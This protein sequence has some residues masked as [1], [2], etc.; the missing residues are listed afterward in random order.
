MKCPVLG[1]I[2]SLFLVLTGFA[3]GTSAQPLALSLGDI[4][5]AMDPVPEARIYV[6]KRIITMDPRR[7]RGEAVAVLGGRILAVGSLDDLIHAAGE[8]PLPVDETF[9]DKVLV[10]GFIDP[11]V[12]PALA[13][14][15]FDAEIISFEDWALPDGLRPG[16][17]GHDEYLK[18]LAEAQ[19]RLGDGKAVMV[20]WGYHEG[21]H[22]PLTRDD[23]DAISNKR[24]IIVWHRSGRMFILNSPAIERYGISEDFLARLPASAQSDSDRPAG[25]FRGQGA[26]AILERISPALAEPQALRK[27]LELLE[28][29]LHAGGLTAIASPDEIS[30]GSL[31][32][33]QRAVLGDDATPFRT[34][35]LPDGRSIAERFRADPRRMLE[36]TRALSER[37]GGRNRVLPG[38]VRLYLDGSLFSARM[39]VTGGYNDGEQGAWEMDPELFASAFESYWDAGYQI[40]VQVN[41]DAA[42]QLVLERLERE[43]RRKPR[44]DHRTTL[45]HFGMASEAQIQQ[46]A[47]LRVAVCGN[48]HVVTAMADLYAHN[49]LGPERADN[50]VPLGAAKRAGLPVSLCSDL[51]MAPAQPLQLIWSAVNRTTLS[52]RVAGSDQRLG[53]EDALAAVTINAA[54]LLRLEDEVGSIEP[55]KLANFTVLESDPFEVPPEQLRSIGV[56][57]TVLEG[58]V[59]AVARPILPARTAA[60][61]PRVAPWLAPV[62]LFESV[63]VAWNRVGE[64]HR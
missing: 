52:G 7:P 28:A 35:Y 15:V 37:A 42:L 51:P 18:R 11:Q 41:G 58:R 47:R 30:P 61:S 43:M 29:Y 36:E 50:L 14:L 3:P 10:P 23:L 1:S 38:Q 34:H 49:G 56:W 16:V 22:G 53:I 63:P 21:F 55:G 46:L 27:G 39:E 2:L 13:A 9:R 64:V 20:T 62:R 19:T 45:V 26:L 6:A 8:Q 44:Y 32:Q 4:R 33:A 17:R 48:P 59:Q 54:Y 12:H 60:V 24:P 40:H 5:A 25:C 31:M 57:G